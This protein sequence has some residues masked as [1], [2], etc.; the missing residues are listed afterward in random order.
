[1]VSGIYDKT[2]PRKKAGMERGLGRQSRY[3]FPRI[4]ELA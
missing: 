3:C 1:M 2:P 4:I